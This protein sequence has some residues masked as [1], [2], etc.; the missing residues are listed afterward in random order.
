[1]DKLL[2]E[3]LFGTLNVMHLIDNK[4]DWQ[5]IKEEIKYGVT[6]LYEITEIVLEKLKNWLND[7]NNFEKDETDL[8]E[9]CYNELF[10]IWNEIIYNSK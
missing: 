9:M 2:K 4:T 6:S 10:I 5:E 7:E 3:E 1:M 8:L